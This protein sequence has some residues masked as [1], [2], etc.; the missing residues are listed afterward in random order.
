MLFSV[1]NLRDYLMLKT[2]HYRNAALALG[3]ETTLELALGACSDGYPQDGP[4]I[5]EY[6]GDLECVVVSHSNEHGRQ[7]LHLAIFETGAGAAVIETLAQIQVNEEPAPQAKEFIRSQAFLICSGHDVIFT[8]HNAPLR[9]SRVNVL[10]N[11]LIKA[12]GGFQSCPNFLLQA[13][14]DEERYREIMDQGISEIDLGIGGFKQTLEHAVQK[15]RVEQAGLMNVI[16]SLYQRELTEADKQAAEKIS[17]RFVLRPGR[18]WD[19]AE[20]KQIMTSMALKLLDEDYEDGFAII[21]K[22]GLRI[23]QNSVRLTESFSVDGNRQVVNRT[24]MFA[25]LHLAFDKFLEL[26]VIGDEGMV[27]ESEGG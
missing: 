10:I 7:Q 19:E 18:N 24:Q 1:L 8:T 2:G 12:F 26:G 17:G 9:D 3:E 25:G 14:I 11:N 13:A 27:I 21:T 16:G 23:T 15:G 22:N 20:V 6:T 5:F 4:P